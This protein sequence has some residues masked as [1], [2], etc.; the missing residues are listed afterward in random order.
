[1]Q[2]MTA[3]GALERTTPFQAPVTPSFQNAALTV[4]AGD[5][6]SWLGCSAGRKRSCW[7]SWS[8]EGPARGCGRNP[9]ADE[10]LTVGCRSAVRMSTCPG[11]P[12]WSPEQMLT[13]VL[14]E[15]Y[16]LAD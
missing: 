7:R 4:E 15:S 1:M 10:A 11:G 2:M 6:C 8:R 9:A 12:S 3:L 5:S 14:W 13:F 16:L